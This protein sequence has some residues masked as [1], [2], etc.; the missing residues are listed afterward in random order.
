MITVDA[1]MQT[2]YEQLCTS[3]YKPRASYTMSEY[4]ESELLKPRVN[5]FVKDSTFDRTL[6]QQGPAAQI[7]KD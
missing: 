3:A 6:I 4:S 2:L 5:Q 1:A 7:K